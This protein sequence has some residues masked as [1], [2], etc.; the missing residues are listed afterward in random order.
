MAPPPEGAR[1]HRRSRHPAGRAR[2]R[3]A[4]RGRGAA[5]ARRPDRSA[6]ARSRAASA[7]SGARAADPGAGAA[8]GP[9]EQD[10]R[11]AVEYRRERRGATSRRAA[12]GAPLPPPEAAAPPPKRCRQRLGPVADA[13]S[14][15]PSTASVTSPATGPAILRLVLRVAIVAAVLTAV[16]AVEDFLAI[17]GDVA[18]DHLHLSGQRPRRGVLP[19]D[20]CLAPRRCAGGPSR[21]SGAVRRDRRRHL[22]SAADGPQ[23][24][25]HARE[26]PASRRRARPGAQPTGFSSGVGGGGCVGGIRWPGWY[27]PPCM[28][29]WPWWCSTRRAA[30]AVLLSRSRQRRGGRGACSIFVC[31]A[32]C[33][34]AV[35]YALLA[36]NRLATPR[37]NRRRMKR[38]ERRIRSM[39]VMTRRHAEARA[40]LRLPG[41]LRRTN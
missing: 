17:R 21:S 22:E 1:R 2:R 11:P 28:S 23:H 24:G 25:L 33:V 5:R 29:C 30:S 32:A 14:A 39:I 3:A 19:V 8:P 4:T 41:L 18:A 9:A 6:A 20:A 16:I 12:P 15:A 10:Q 26:H 34:L 38:S 37:P 40:N 13:G 27:I 7:G 36:V 35:G 31:W